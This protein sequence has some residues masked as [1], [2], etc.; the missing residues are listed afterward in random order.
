VGYIL[1]LECNVS[2]AGKGAAMKG[3]FIKK[4]INKKYN[5]EL[6]TLK[7][8]PDNPAWCTLVEVSIPHFYCGTPIVLPWLL[9]PSLLGGPLPLLISSSNL[10]SL[11]PHDL[12]S[13][14]PLQ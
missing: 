8:A 12:G 5:Y 10:L 3:K 1:L 7:G 2:G 14:S 11:G 9:P 13:F 4:L 6:L